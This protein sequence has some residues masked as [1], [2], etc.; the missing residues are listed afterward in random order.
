MAN[1]YFQEYVPKTTAITA[2]TTKYSSSAATAINPMA[3]TASAAYIIIILL[4]T[5]SYS[6]GTSTCIFRRYIFHIIMDEWETKLRR[7]WWR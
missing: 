5:P 2:N 6:H 4:L 3:T 1:F 7:Q